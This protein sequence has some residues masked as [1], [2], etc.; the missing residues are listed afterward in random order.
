MADQRWRGAFHR[1]ALG[2]RGGVVEAVDEQAWAGLADEPFGEAGG[3]AAG[4]LKV[5]TK[6]RRADRRVAVD[7]FEERFLEVEGAG[8]GRQ[9][10]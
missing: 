9:A 8:H 3:V 4:G 1:G 5:R 7:L 6:G 10:P 2:D